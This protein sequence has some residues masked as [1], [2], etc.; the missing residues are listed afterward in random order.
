MDTVL[1]IAWRNVLRN[2][3]RS[4]ITIA[5]LMIGIVALLFLWAFNDGSYN[6]AI[7]NFRLRYIGSI[8]VHKQDFFRRPKLETRIDDPAAVIAAVE[9][10]GVDAWTTRLT[11]FALVAGEEI[12]AGMNLVG[13]DPE[14]EPAVSILDERIITGRYLAPGEAGTAML[15][16]RA[17]RKLDVAVGGTIVLLS[18]DRYGAMTADRFEVVGLFVTGDPLLDESSAFVSLADARTLLAMEGRVTDVVVQVPE[19]DLDAKTAALRAAL[20]GEDME[21]LRWHDMSTLVLDAQTLD[22][23][24]AYIFLG[25]VVAIA[26]SG[27]ANAVLV[28]M[29]QRTREFGVLLALGTRRTAVGAMI[30]A[31]TLMLGI[32]GTLA[33]TAAGLGLVA[34]FHRTGI[35]MRN[36]MEGDA[37]AGMLAEFAMDPVVYPVVNTD[38]LVVTVGLMIAAS[39]LSAIYPVW[40]AMQLEPVEAIR[41]V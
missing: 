31:E 18:A 21:V 9:G 34:W 17:A 33:G 39:V 13:I 40:R 19:R 38:H 7:D 41:H 24:F 3:R 14:R 35:D 23:A 27:I 26:V 1:A 25:I 22:R 2:R 16:A 37:L 30:A 11:S 4:L 36:L 29:M 28:S 8:Q 15:G 10:V 5:S 32:A 20:D 6:N 12:S